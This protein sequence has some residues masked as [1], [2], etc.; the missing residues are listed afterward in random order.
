MLLNEN[1]IDNIELLAG[2]AVKENNYQQ[3]LKYLE[4]YLQYR[5][6]PENLEFKFLLKIKHEGRPP[7]VCPKNLDAQSYYELGE[8]YQWCGHWKLA[9][10]ALK[11]S[12]KAD[13]QGIFAEKSAQFIKRRLPLSALSP[14]LEQQL[15]DALKI[16]DLSKRAKVLIELFAKEKSEIIGVEIAETFYHQEKYDVAIDYLEICLDINHL[17]YTARRFMVD[18]LCINSQW[19]EALDFMESWIEQDP[20]D[21]ELERL[22]ATVE[23]RLGID[24]QGSSTEWK[25]E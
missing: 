19:S 13:S 23:M 15:K 3:A 6:K 24:Y 7:D 12:I 25:F 5:A 1:Y 14:T 11:R 18:L 4:R 17:F 2:I 9:R 16:L 20:E 10:T 8:L 21:L 22:R